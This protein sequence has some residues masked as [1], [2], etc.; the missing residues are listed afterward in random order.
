MKFLS[1]PYRS[2]GLVVF[3]SL[4]AG[5]LAIPMAGAQIS[6]VKQLFH[7]IRPLLSHS[8]SPGYLGVLVADVDNESAT[9]LKLKEV[10]GAI[11]TLIDHDAP[12]GQAGLRVNDVVLSLDGKNVEG[13]E[14]FGRM[15]REVSAG[16]KV[17][18]GISR[19]GGTQTL[20]V[21]LVDRK[22]MEH[23]VWNK[24]NNDESFAAPPS[25]LGLLAGGGD[26]AM[27]GFHMPWFGSSLNVG[28][29]VEPLTSQMAD[30]LGVPSGVMVKQVAR[31]SEAAAA[32]LKAFDVVLK[33]G[34]DPIKTTADWDRALRS[35]EGKSVPLTILR[36][37]RQQTINLQVDS[38]RHGRVEYKDLVAPDTSPEMAGL[39]Q[40]LGPGFF[41][42]AKQ[43]HEQARTIG[44]PC[45]RRFGMDRQEPA[46][47]GPAV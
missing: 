47:T 10:R 30:Y 5:A 36:D 16:R 25:G 7:Q 14:Q 37:R 17:T 19:E 1:R 12:A 18:L 44:Q 13:A 26:S 24:M 15:L 6:Q 46:V 32:G 9:K 45:E 41:A 21:Q 8:N 4:G 34:A 35:N 22:T 2:L 27:P 39:E 33:V 28:A 38:K 29:L 23:D 43:L 42:E 20:I 31:K 11:I 3:A 40:Y